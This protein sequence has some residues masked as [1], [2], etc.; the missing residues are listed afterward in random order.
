MN[1]QMPT[2][3]ELLVM[4][5]AFDEFAMNFCQE[6]NMAPLAM[7]GVF[8]A[9]MTK[10]AQEFEYPGEYT[11]LLIEI[12]KMNETTQAIMADTSTAIH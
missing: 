6:H 5:G 8:L 9:R 4:A 3:E 12:V 1:T 7:T 11:R 2:N 10:M